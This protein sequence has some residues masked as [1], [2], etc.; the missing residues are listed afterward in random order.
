MAQESSGFFFRVSANLLRLIG[1]ELVASDEVAVLEL[2]KNAYDSKASTVTI[3]IEPISEKRV[4]VIRIQDDGQGMSRKDFDHLFMAAAYS[5]RPEEAA[6]AKRVPTGEKGIGRFA[7]SRLGGRLTL[8]TR[9]AVHEPKVLKVEFDWKKFHDK[10]KKFDE[11]SIPWEH[12]SSNML[13]KGQTGTVLEV[14]GL[15]SDWRPDRIERLRLS[16]AELLD[17]FHKP[18]DFKIFLDVVGSQKLS[19]QVVQQ[20]PTGA[21]LDVEFRVLADEKVSR[22]LST[23]SLGAENQREAVAS[24]ANTQPLVGLSGRFLYF[25]KRPSKQ[26]SKGLPVAV[27]IYRDGVRV[28]PFGSP[29]ADWLGVSEKKAKRAGHAHVVPSRLYGFIEISRI[30]HQQLIDTTGRQALIDNEAAEGLVTLLQEQLG[31]LEEKIRTLVSVPKWEA[32]KQ[33]KLIKLERARL[34]AL[35]MLSAGLGHELR[36]PLQV[37]RTQT[38]NLHDRLS[39]LKI[40]DPEINTYEAAIDRNIQRMNGSIDYIAQLAKGDVEK[41][42]NF[43]LAEHLREDSRYM[44]SQCRANGINVEINAPQNQAARISQTG[45]SI[46]LLNLLKN[47]AEAFDEVSERSDKRISILLSKD[48]LD[49]ILEVTDNGTGINEDTEKR[50]FKE[51][52][53]GKTGGMGI[54]LYTCRVIVEAH[55]G[56][57]TYK[58]RIGLGTTFR[59]RFPDR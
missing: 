16:L 54:G 38:G 32:G 20:P 33:K 2:V 27:R 26:Q 12:I 41:A 23:S 11:I 24:S 50:L 34:H 25:L 42:D 17:P 49:N 37:I 4:G 3:T 52:E 15:R 56:E 6:S 47:A 29:I 7:A 31:F 28:E 19:G 57:I 45:F 48:G 21:D 46:V 51:F 10:T 9:A 43:D 59:V 44:D 1:E 55:G 40:N 5:E 14:T 13:P 53:T 58:T 8:L 30:K 35:G 22:K 36:Q 39:E 18:G